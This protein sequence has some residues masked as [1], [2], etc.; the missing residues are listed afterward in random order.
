[1]ASG[2]TRIKSDFISRLDLAMEKNEIAEDK[3]L[4]IRARI[5]AP[6]ISGWRNGP[7]WPRQR[8]LE[9]VAAALHVS[10]DWLIGDS[11]SEPNWNSFLEKQPL[12]VEEEPDIGCGAPLRSW[13][14]APTNKLEILLEECLED[15]DYGAVS[16]VADEL[17]NRKI[18]GRLK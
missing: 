5:S 6:S 1:M 7:S 18:Q 4:A 12:R 8:H 13:K 3:E 9:D 14:F 2:K 15:R 17:F 11:D 10:A 16:K